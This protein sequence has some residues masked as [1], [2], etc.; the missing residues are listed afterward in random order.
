MKVTMKI[1]NVVHE[2]VFVHVEAASVA[3]A[4]KQMEDAL[5]LVGF[6]SLKFKEPVVRKAVETNVDAWT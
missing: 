6:D 3:K 4:K 1:T 5:Q 2:T